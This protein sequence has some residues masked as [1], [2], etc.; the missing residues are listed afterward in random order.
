MDKASIS[1]LRD[2][3]SAHLRRV[4]AGHALVI[5]DRDVPV[6]RLERI[7]ASGSGSGRLAL[8]ESQGITRPPAR[9]LSRAA[10]LELVAA[11]LPR[12]ARLAEALQQERAESQ[13]A[14]RPPSTSA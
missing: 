10:I 5:C 1:E 6:A 7:E 4:R 3:L 13:H 2:N 8:L 12:A 9:P 14:R 11:P